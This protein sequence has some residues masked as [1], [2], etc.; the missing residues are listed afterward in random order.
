MYDFQASRWLVSVAKNH[1]GRYPVR[2]VVS[3]R[4]VVLIELVTAG[5]TQLPFCSRGSPRHMKA[6]TDSQYY[7]IHPI[8]I[9][10]RRRSCFLFIIILFRTRRTRPWTLQ[11]IYRFLEMNESS[12]EAVK[13]YIGVV[14]S[15][16]LLL[17]FPACLSSNQEATGQ[18]VLSP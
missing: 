6:Q 4:S 10:I 16:E 15:I 1:W 12:S 8:S 18:D 17:R 2:A 11:P 14:G 5:C 3:S 9:V 13:V 7:I